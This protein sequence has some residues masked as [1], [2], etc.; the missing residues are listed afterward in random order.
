MNI[1]IRIGKRDKR[2][3]VGF[4]ESFVLAFL[5]LSNDDIISYTPGLKK[6]MDFRGMGP[7]SRTSR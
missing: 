2:E 1:F 6:G 3:E 4:K 5:Y 7:V